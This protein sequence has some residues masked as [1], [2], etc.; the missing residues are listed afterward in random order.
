V[1]ARRTASSCTCM[2]DRKLSHLSIRCGINVSSEQAKFLVD[3]DVD[4]DV[5]QG[6]L[7]AHGSTLR[8]V[9]TMVRSETSWDDAF[10]QRTWR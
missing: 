8:V 2:T 1:R 4:C 10:T 6:T 9:D 3:C 5:C 7:Q